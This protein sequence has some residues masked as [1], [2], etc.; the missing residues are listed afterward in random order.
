MYFCSLT[1]VIDIID[2]NIAAKLAGRFDR[3]YRLTLVY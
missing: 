2:R 1:I 3:K